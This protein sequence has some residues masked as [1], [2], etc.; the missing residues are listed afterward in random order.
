MKAAGLSFE[1]SI[2]RFSVVRRALGLT[3]AIKAGEAELPSGEDA[4]PE[5]L[6]EA[7]AK[8][9]A[10][11]GISGV[12]VGLDF[13]HFT[14]HFTEL[15]LKARRD[16]KSALEFEVEKFLP[17]PAEEYIYDFHSWPSE[18]GSKVLV[19]AV[20]KDK[21]GWIAD[22]VK[23]SGL[24]LLGVKCS[25]IEVINEFISSGKT[26]AI[27]ALPSSGGTCHLAGISGK[28]PSYLKAARSGD[29]SREVEK[30]RD[31]H[32]GG[33]Y[34]AGAE[35]GELAKE[36]DELN[37]SKLPYSVSHLAA[38][39]SFGRRAVALDFSPSEEALERA[40]F[41][42]YFAGILTAVSVALFIST[43]IVSYYKD[44]AALEGVERRISQI[45][46]TAKG[47][48]E[49]K[50]SL[51][52]IEEKVKFLKDSRRDSGTPMRALRELSTSVPDDSWL[53]EYSADKSGRV[54]IKGW[55][56][57]ASNLIEPIEKSPM[58]K[59]VEFSSAVTQ[60]EGLQKFSIRMQVEK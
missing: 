31:T 30:L 56:K 39:S 3:K 53:T 58:F 6:R 47:L 2:V 21:V 26:D 54:E 13:S 36:L 32:T 33:L 1:G 41:Y 9:R 8:L 48:I 5:A 46:E 11:F 49:T 28:N 45:K 18:A 19:L 50:R 38:V 42:P 10:D 44:R 16:I 60:R 29:I 27:L 40:D 55:A 14:H 23:S 51:E 17:L 59:G 4:Q 7:L 12:S 57:R 34:V 52:E 20:R 25:F 37:P 24:K 43:D 35:S 15:P 22:A